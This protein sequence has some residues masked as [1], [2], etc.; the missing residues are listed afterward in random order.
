VDLEDFVHQMSNQISHKSCVQL[1]T[2][3]LFLPRHRGVEMHA[4]YV[5]FRTFFV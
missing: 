2:L 3:T 5:S 4:H 1:Q